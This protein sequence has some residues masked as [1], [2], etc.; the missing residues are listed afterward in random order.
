MVN[1]TIPTYCRRISEVSNGTTP[2]ASSDYLSRKAAKVQ[3][4][5]RACQALGHTV[6]PRDRIRCVDI[7][8]SSTRAIADGT[9]TVYPLVSEG[10]LAV[11]QS[12]YQ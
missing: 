2:I 7:V 12:K 3:A 5:K 8:K 10:L 4:L 6:V 1:M 11:G 9:E